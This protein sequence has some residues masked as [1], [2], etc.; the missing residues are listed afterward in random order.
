MD[1]TTF[2]VTLRSLDYIKL[3]RVGFTLKSSVNYR[4]VT[5]VLSL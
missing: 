2:Y 4:W 1:M 5:Y 3:K